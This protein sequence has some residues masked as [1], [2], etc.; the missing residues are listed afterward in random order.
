MTL[1]R[2]ALGAQTANCT[3]DTPFTVTECAPSFSLQ[4]T[5][6]PLLERLYVCI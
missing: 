6:S 5:M 2:S 1:T 4:A 3:P